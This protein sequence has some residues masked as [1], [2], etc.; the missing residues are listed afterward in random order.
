MSTAPTR[1]L[2]GVYP[3]SMKDKIIA[4]VFVVWASVATSALLWTASSAYG[5]VD[6]F[7]LG[8]AAVFVLFGLTMLETNLRTVTV[9]E[10]EISQRSPIG[11]YRQKLKHEHLSG[12]R[13]TYLP[14]GSVV[15]VCHHGRWIYLC[16]NR[17]FRR[18]LEREPPVD[19]DN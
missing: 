17:T 14:R 10:D 7:T 6:T 4:A 2:I 16:S 9:G 18:R 3:P 11:I 5:G 15:E 1:E 8:F 13:L 19:A 12:I